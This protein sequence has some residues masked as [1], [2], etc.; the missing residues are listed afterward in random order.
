MQLSPQGLPFLQILQH[1][2]LVGC[3]ATVRFFFLLFFF[4]LGVWAMPRG[5]CF[6]GRVV[7]GFLSTDVGGRCTTPSQGQGPKVFH[8]EVS[9][10]SG[11]KKNRPLADP[12]VSRG[13]SDIAIASFFATTSSGM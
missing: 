3:G 9:V 12:L 1:V 5:L 4:G 10:P 11:T 6:L 7:L 8:V 2:R 13:C